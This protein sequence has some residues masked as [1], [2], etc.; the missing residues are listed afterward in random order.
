VKERME[1]EKS[2][3]D[4]RRKDSNFLEKEGG[5]QGK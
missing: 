3:Q 2:Y 4:R 1:E 5:M